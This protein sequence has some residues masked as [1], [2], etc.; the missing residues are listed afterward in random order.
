M[1][2]SEPAE[3]AL[4][5]AKRELRKQMKIVLSGISHDSIVK[6]SNT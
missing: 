4:L 2:S 1:S 3:M 5:L 6:Q